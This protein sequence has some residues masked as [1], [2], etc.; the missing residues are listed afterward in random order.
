MTQQTPKSPYYKPDD[1]KIIEEFSTWD[2]FHENWSQSESIFALGNGY[3][4][5]RGTFEE[6][7]AQIRHPND[8]DTKSQSTTPGVKKVVSVDGTYLNGFYESQKVEY[9][10]SAYGYAENSQTMLN[11]PNGKPILVELS[12]GTVSEKLQ[13]DSGTLEAYTRTL[14]MQT[15]LL[16][17][18]LIWASPT[19][20]LKVEL[21]VKRLVSFKRSHIAAIEFR[22]IPYFNGSIQLTSILNGNVE[23]VSAEKD[24][25]IGSHL[26]GCVLHAVEDPVISAEGGILKQE[27]TQ[28]GLLLVSAMANVLET[29]SPLKK[30]PT[31][32]PSY[33]GEKENEKQ[34]VI[35]VTYD[36]V[37]ES[38]TPITLHK[39]LAYSYAIN[40]ESSSNTLV[41]D[42]QNELAAVRDLG[43]DGLENEQRTYMKHFWEQ[44]N[45]SVKGRSSDVALLQQG[46]RFNMFHLLQAAGRDGATNIGSKGLTGEGY[47]GHYFW[48][49]EMFAA[50]FF[51][52]V[53]PDVCRKL[54]E[55]RYG[56]LDH[57]RTRAR[58][59]AH[60]QGAAYAWRTINGEE[61]SAFFPAGTAQYHIN[62][63]IA[64]AIK[65]YVASSE[66]TQFLV[67]KGAE[68]VFETARLWADLG[69]YVPERGNAFCIHGV[70]GPDEY[71]AIVDNNCY[72]NMMAQEN[73]RYA[74]DV[75]RWLKANHPQEYDKIV[76]ELEPPL[77]ENELLEWTR[78]ADAMYIPRDTQTGLLAQDDGFFNRAAWRWD[79]GQRDGK[80]V[81]L[82]RFHYLVIYRHQVC[83]QADVV[84]ALY[85]LPDRASLEEKRRNFNYYEQ[86]TTH[87][88]SLSTCTFG[89]IASEIGYRG[90]AY[91]YFMETARMDLDDHHGNVTAGVHIANMAG[92]WMSV[93]NGF[94]GL[95]LETS[96]IPGESIPHYKPY[97]PEAWDEYSFRVRHRQ[98]GILQVTL[99]R[100]SDNQGNPIVETAYQ[101]ITDGAQSPSIKL[102]HHS[103]LFEL[104]QHN[105]QRSFVLAEES[106]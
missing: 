66:D 104:D 101:L 80:D 100:K 83:K 103:I 3:I 15:G 5:M 44:A 96:N 10:E 90:R 23:N 50:P 61:C 51:Q 22:L 63:D 1:W 99:T 28:S 8:P 41:T 42:V 40:N 86:I 68:I 2:E 94:A 69:E 89:I 58:K 12:D 91:N 74:C 73:L 105:S 57:A 97:L 53:E 81:L 92:A 14:D 36:V 84:L 16:V 102:K 71:T 11:V 46:I 34:N 39:Y 24:P 65:S 29:G 85:L 87:D 35:T 106:V 77:A 9:P 54:L 26:K 98:H 55:Y 19:K 47:E 6:G 88:S 4:G 38:G 31:S 72:T 79:W 75:A 18:S 56:I 93:V 37:A 76:S 82:K 13:I 43:F 78:A 32:I 17:R 20:N 7:L 52:Y 49:T 95:R 48:D 25:R 59:L 67:D 60:K 45:V 70:T 30:T 64:Y 21:Q 27:T 62:A 33:A